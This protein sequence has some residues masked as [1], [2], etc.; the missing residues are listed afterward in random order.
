MEFKYIYYVIFLIELSKIFY[1]M[2]IM[3]GKIQLR[4]NNLY[5]GLLII[6]DFRRTHSKSHLLTKKKLSTLRMDK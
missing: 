6:K 2:E 5:S 4:K 1:K 3:N